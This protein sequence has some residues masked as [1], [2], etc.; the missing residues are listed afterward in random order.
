MTLKQKLINTYLDYI[1]NYLTKERFAED[2]GLTM[3]SA[4]L[5]LGIGKKLH[6]EQVLQ[7]KRAKND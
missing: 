4:R 3:P 6:N 5:L 1:N 7:N 2:Y